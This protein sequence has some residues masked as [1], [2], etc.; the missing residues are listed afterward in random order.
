MPLQSSE[1]I[2]TVVDN[3]RSAR[4]SWGLWPARVVAAFSFSV[5]VALM[6]HM[7]LPVVAR[8]PEL[9]EFGSHST[10]PTITAAA[11]GTILSFYVLRVR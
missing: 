6:M 11:I 2:N 1:P 5:P 3:P 8:R 9:A 7:L 10:L 4:P